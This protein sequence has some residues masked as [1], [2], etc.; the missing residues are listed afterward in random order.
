MVVIKMD[1]NFN[2]NNKK[3]SE[4]CPSTVLNAVPSNCRAILFAELRTGE[5]YQDKAIVGKICQLYP[6]G[7]RATGFIRKLVITDALPEECENA[8]KLTVFLLDQFA[9][10]SNAAELE[11]YIIIANFLLEKSTLNKGNELPFQVLVKKEE[12]QVLFGRK[13]PPGEAKSANNIPKPTHRK[14]Q[15][16]AND[17][18]SHVILANSYEYAPIEALQESESKITYNIY[19]IVE[20]CNLKVIQGKKTQIL[21]LT[22]TDETEAGFSCSVFGAKDETFP[23]VYPGDIVRIHRMQGY[24]QSSVKLGPYHFLYME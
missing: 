20:S 3:Q 15:K 10:E 12:T 2:I 24:G 6:T 18:E 22:L 11:G 23:D 19:G 17:E 14:K 16:V 21:D 8:P 4:R 5:N 9:Q 13:V 7:K 1:Q